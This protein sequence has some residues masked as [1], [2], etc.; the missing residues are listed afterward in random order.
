MTFGEQLYLIGVV[1]AFT[2]FAV[3]LATVCW[4]ER[5]PS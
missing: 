3:T 4:L 5:E 1:G 2:V